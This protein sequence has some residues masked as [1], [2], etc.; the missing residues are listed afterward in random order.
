MARVTCCSAPKCSFKNTGLQAPCVS[1]K[2][3][4]DQLHMQGGAPLGWKE[5]LRE[6]DDRRRS[7]TCVPQG[8]NV[9]HSTKCPKQEREKNVEWRSV[10]LIIGLEH[11]VHIFIYSF[12]VLRKKKNKTQQLQ[13][14]STRCHWW[15][16]LVTICKTD[17]VNTTEWKSNERTTTLKFER[18]MKKMEVTMEWQ[19]EW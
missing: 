13:A 2:C 19:Q 8:E 15:G 1:S 16:W 14:K 17:R 5:G 10:Q 4:A 9:A 3:N 7:D 18:R 6:D 12:P 11:T